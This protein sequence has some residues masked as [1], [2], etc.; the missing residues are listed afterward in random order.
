MSHHVASRRKELARILTERDVSTR[1]QPLLSA[2]DGRLYA[3]E[4]LL[5][6]PAG[7]SLHE[8][9]ALFA[10]AEGAGLSVELDLLALESSLKSFAS[11]DVPGK[12]FVN[13][14]PETV[15]RANLP[16]RLQQMLT[17]CRL[18]PQRLVVE[19]TEHGPQLDAAP[20]CAEGRRLRELG[21]EI[22][23]DDFGTGIS[24]L[25]IWSELRPDYVKVDR[26]FIARIETDPVAVELLRAMLDMAHVLGS[27]VVAEGIETATQLELL[28]GTGVDYLQG[29]YISKPLE[30][31]TDQTGNYNVLPLQ[32]EKTAEVSCVGDLCFDREPVSPQMRIVDAVAVFRNNP[33]WE[34]LPVVQ[35]GKPLGLLQRDALLLLLS[36]PLY[37]EI[38]NPKPVSKVMEVAALVI[39]ERSRLSQA[40]RLITRN[41]QSRINEEFIVARDGRYRGLARS[42]ELLHH[43]TEERLREAQQS[44]PLTLLPGNREI[45]SEVFRL[46]A[47]KVPFVICHAD[48]DHFKPFNDQYGYSQGDQVLLHLAGLCR[49]AAVPGLDFVGHPGGDDFILV[50]RS[51]DW[52]RRITRIVDSFTASCSRFYSAEHIAAGGFAGVDR[53]GRD[54]KFPLMTL[55]V[56]AAVID[57]E[58]HATM[59]DLMRTVGSAK[60]R[61]KSRVGNAMIVNNGEVDQTLRLPTLPLQE[62][63]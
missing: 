13:V 40:S 26:Y 3:H 41:R 23:I 22:A 60:Q 46:S 31:A 50:M 36:K 32:V 54:R 59:A 21:C 18:D 10:E 33:Q 5:R 17:N 4:A 25:K 45:D 55:S 34:S 38:Y 53:D 52:N 2:I 57:P 37:P 8:P 49:S 11:R 20:L 9:L 62:V 51:G 14:L 63:G 1:F 6:G 7:S 12:L 29:Y 30:Q 48:I 44:N 35:D 15:L 42:V 24:G 58:R 16:E 39:D 28:R 61:A 47:L 19:I 27:R 43:I 56:G